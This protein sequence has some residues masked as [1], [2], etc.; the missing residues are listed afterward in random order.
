MSFNSMKELINLRLKN[1][2][3]WLLERLIYEKSVFGGANKIQLVE[4]EL[5]KD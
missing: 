1:L 5:A 2:I 3:V 4:L